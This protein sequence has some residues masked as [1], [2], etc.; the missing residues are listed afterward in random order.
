M[1]KYFQFNRDKLTAPPG[2]LIYVGDEIAQKVNINIFTYD[3][4]AY[5]EREIE[6]LDDVI[7]EKDKPTVTWINIDGIHDPKI[8]EKIGTKFEIHPLLLEDIMNS[9][10]RIKLEDFDTYMFIV[11]KMAYHREKSQTTK[12]DIS[13]D[14]VIEQVSLILGPNYVISFQECPGD[15][16]DSIRDRIRNAKGRIR[17]AGADFLAYSLMDAIVD[18]YFIVLESF[19]EK[20]EEIE[21][22]VVTNPDP[23][24]LQILQTLRKEIILLRRSV[25]PLREVISVIE[26]TET[27]LIKKANH[28]YF[29]DIYDHLIQIMETIEGFRELVGGMLEIYLSSV[30]NKM[31]EVMK[32]LTIIAT[33][34]IPL[35]FI[36]GLYGMNFNI[37]PE[38]DWNFGYPFALLIMLGIGIIMLFYFRRRKWI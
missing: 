4:V 6:N 22:E 2:T 20:I 12:D 25:L 28:I 23:K 26:R 14:I 31:N 24:I 3:E 18:N 35:T 29:R 38:T 37:M 36:A 19:G 34:F 11:L 17:K 9:E 1:V 21:D 7:I 27:K 15:V 13:K 32:V 5:K 30:S 33:I 10:Q 8:I 16:F